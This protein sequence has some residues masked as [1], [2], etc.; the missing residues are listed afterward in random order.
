M[1]RNEGKGKGG[2]TNEA[3]VECPD[4]VAYRVEVALDEVR[5][6]SATQESQTDPSEEEG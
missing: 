1:S 4:V 5:D 6:V 2:V 3:L